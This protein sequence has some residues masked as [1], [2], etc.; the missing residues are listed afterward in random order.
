MPTGLVEFLGMEGDQKGSSRAPM[1]PAGGLRRRTA[2]GMDQVW[3]S[4]MGQVVPHKPR[5]QSPPQ[6]PV[7]GAATRGGWIGVAPGLEAC[8]R[9]PLQAEGPVA[10]SCH[11]PQRN[12][13]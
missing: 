12:P 7:H 11:L 1:P 5:T 13:G 4:L 8:V 10:L 9:E 3:R 2:V 6:A